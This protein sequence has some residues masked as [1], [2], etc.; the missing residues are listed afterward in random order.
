M[1]KYLTQIIQV[2]DSIE[3]N[4][5]DD[6][7]ISRLAGEIG[8]S[9]WHF[10]R[11]FKSYVG[12]S[13]GGYLRGR[14]LSVALDLLRNS[15]LGILDIAVEVGFNSHE[16]FTRSFKQKFAIGPKEF[17]DTDPIVVTTKKPL[18]SEDLFAH[19]SKG[20][21]REPEILEMPKMFLSGQ[22]VQIPSPF[23]TEENICEIIAIPW[24]KILEHKAPD[25][26]KNYIG[27]TISPS[28]DYTEKEL[29]F[30]CSEIFY[31]KDDISY[32]DIRLDIPKQKV[33]A[34]TI[35]SDIEEDVARNTVD[36]IYGYWLPN[37][38]YN[39]GKGHDYEYFGNV[40]DFMN[41]GSFE[42]KYIVPIEE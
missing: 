23:E 10:Q 39:R 30:L 9:T 13:L 34:F 42:Y 27:V 38:K 20:I 33:A 14:R 2:V 18:L 28:G 8:I 12:D 15:K 21:G 4:M 3:E 40:V 1:N 29:Q 11:L 22:D 24:F 26:A 31:N 36:Y 35:H 16:A 17:R 25:E 7:N 6:L 41:P 19:I 37:S 32:G 5:A